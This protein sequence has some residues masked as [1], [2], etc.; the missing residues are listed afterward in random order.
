MERFYMSSYTYS[1]I[2]LEIGCDCREIRDKLDELAEYNADYSED[3]YEEF[4]LWKEPT[5]ELEEWLDENKGSDLDTGIYYDL[6]GL[7]RIVELYKE[8]QE[9]TGLFDVNVESIKKQVDYL[10]SYIY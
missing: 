6:R 2:L 5:D 1:E 9:H 8:A 10:T 7:D 3:Y 4:A